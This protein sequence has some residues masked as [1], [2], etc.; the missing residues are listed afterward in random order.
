MIMQAESKACNIG[1][2]LMNTSVVEQVGLVLDAKKRPVKIMAKLKKNEDPELI[3]TIFEQNLGCNYG[4]PCSVGIEATADTV[5]ID[6]E[7]IHDKEA[8]D[9]VIGM[10]TVR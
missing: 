4:C 6:R 3:K 8:F 5:T 7:K 9:M 2:V 1:S 10:L